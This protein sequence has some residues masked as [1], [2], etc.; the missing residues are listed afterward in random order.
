MFLTL[1]LFIA[2]NKAGAKHPH[3]QMQIYLKHP[4]HGT[5]IATMEL[6][7]EYDETNGWVRDNP[8][9]PEVEVAEPVNTLKRRR[10]TTE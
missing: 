10:K 6:E 8:D 4:T 7:A 5:K 2:L 1:Q 3:L 9:T